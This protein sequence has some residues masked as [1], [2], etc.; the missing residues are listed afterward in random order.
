MDHA[1]L[2]RV[3]NGTAHCEEQFQP[4]SDCHLL[5]IAVLRDGCALDVLHDEVRPALGRRACV[6]D[7]CDIRV[8]HHRQ[9][10]ALVGEASEYLA[11]IHPEFHYFKG[12]TPANGFALLGQVHG[13]HTPFAKR[14]NDL[15]SAEVVLTG[16]RA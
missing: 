3:L 6:E 10:L 5:A 14:S 1:F 7:P 4:L 9:R 12:H 11:G 8:V 2:V 15:I 13:A 16:C